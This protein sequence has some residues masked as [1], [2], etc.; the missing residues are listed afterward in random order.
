M[1]GT[2]TIRSAVAGLFSQYCLRRFG[3]VVVERGR[4]V[5]AGRARCWV[6]EGAGAAAAAAVV[7]WWWV[8]VSLG[9]RSRCSQACVWGG[10]WLVVV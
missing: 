5:V 3:V 4:V 9:C 1:G 6:S 10:G 7:V 8:R 2:L